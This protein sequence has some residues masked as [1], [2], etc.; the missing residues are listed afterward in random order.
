MSLTDCYNALMTPAERFFAKVDKTDDCWLWTGGRAV[1]R[2]SRSTYGVFYLG[3]HMGAHRASWILH[4]GAVPPGMQVLH[5]CDNPACVRPDHLFLGDRLANMKDMRDKGRQ[6][7]GQRRPTA[8]I[9]EEVV[10]QIRLLYKPGWH[11]GTNLADLAR[12]FGIHKTAVYL[13]VTRRRWAHVE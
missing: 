11:T 12:H 7:R 3:R 9:T 4:F 10:R 1:D 2:H 5:R 6:C 8:K 13:I